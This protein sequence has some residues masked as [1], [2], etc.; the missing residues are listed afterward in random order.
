MLADERSRGH[1]ELT[2][3]LLFRVGDS[4][5]EPCAKENSALM[6]AWGENNVGESFFKAFII[7]AVCET[8]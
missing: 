4:E 3:H 5:A 8:Q 7:W 6:T 2:G 1:S